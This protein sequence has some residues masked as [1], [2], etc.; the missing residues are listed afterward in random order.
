MIKDYN[1]NRRVTRNLSN[2]K[3]E[4]VLD[5]DWDLAQR[6][7]AGLDKKIALGAYQGQLSAAKKIK[8]IVRRN[9]R[10]DGSGLNWAPLAKSTLARKRRLG[11]SLNRLYA[12]G[13]YY[14]SITII[15]KGLTVKVGV[16]SRTPHSSG[17][18]VS[19]LATIQEFGSNDWRIPARPLW[20][21]SF[22]QFGGG[23]RVISHMNWHIRKQIR[24]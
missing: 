15:R 13:Q 7:L 3:T 1:K 8:R 17:L 16:K 19:Q 21:P 11:Q 20:A 10:Q 4:I 2:Y 14:R 18:T 5:G 9:I 6:V 24:I 23:K 22:K 12:T